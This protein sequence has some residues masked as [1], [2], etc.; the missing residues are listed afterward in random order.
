MKYALLTAA[1]LLLAACIMEPEPKKG[2]TIVVDPEACNH[3][4]GHD[5]RDS[6]VCH[7]GEPKPGPVPQ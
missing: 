7:L 6:I 5:G 4:A 3:I 1:G 2:K